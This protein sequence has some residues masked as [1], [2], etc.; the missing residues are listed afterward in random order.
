MI[1]AP[2]N[3][4]LASVH[5]FCILGARAEIRWR[6]SVMSRIRVNLA[7]F[8]SLGRNTSAITAENLQGIKNYY[9]IIIGECKKIIYICFS[10]LNNI[11]S[12]FS[13]LIFR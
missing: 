10:I 6:S 5:A 9:D 11:V 13:N 2:C 7:A 1:L 4:T 8:T 3:F 12:N